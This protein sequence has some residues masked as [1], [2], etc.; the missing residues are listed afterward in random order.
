MTPEDVPDDLLSLY[1]RNYMGS[2]PRV[3][4]RR[5][6]AA[7]IPEIERQV[8]AQVAAEQRAAAEAI[9]TSRGEDFDPL[10]AAIYDGCER[11]PEVP[12]MRD[13]CRNIAVVAYRHLADRIAQGESAGDRLALVTADDL[14]ELLDYVVGDGEVRVVRNETLD[15]AFAALKATL[16]RGEVR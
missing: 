1:G 11:D 12:A 2:T 9:E 7:V 8:R 3:A 4:A 6:M 13:D 15:R 16:P 10:A 5:A 14:A